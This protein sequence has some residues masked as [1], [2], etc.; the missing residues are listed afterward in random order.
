[1][2]RIPVGDDR[3]AF[4]NLVVTEN[5]MMAQSNAK[6]IVIPVDFPTSFKEIEEF[7]KG[8]QTFSAELSDE[9]INFFSGK[10]WQLMTSCKQRFADE[11]DNLSW[12]DYTEAGSKSADYQRLLAGGLTRSLVVRVSSAQAMTRW[13]WAAFVAP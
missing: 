2:K 7:F 13:W 5:M 10:I 6:P 8:F 11:Y 4:D 3:T 1:M 9:E 12:W